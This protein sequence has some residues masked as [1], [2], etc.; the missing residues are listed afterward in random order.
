MNLVIDIGN[1]F[2][3]VAV[4]SGSEMLFKESIPEIS[5]DGNKVYVGDVFNSVMYVIEKVPANRPPADKPG[6]PHSGSGQ[7][8]L[9]P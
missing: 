4:F 2:I 5:V 6:G 7:A 8:L 3:K 1:S 9:Q